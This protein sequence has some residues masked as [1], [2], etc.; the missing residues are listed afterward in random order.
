MT[1]FE[2]GLSGIGSDHSAN[3]STT[4]T[5]IYSIFVASK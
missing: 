2:P 5:L 3:C 1:G 4:A